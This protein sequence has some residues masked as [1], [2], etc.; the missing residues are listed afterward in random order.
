MK[1]YLDGAISHLQARASHLLGMVPRDRGRELN[2]LIMKCQEEL[3]DLQSHLELLVNH[4]VFVRRETQ[5]LRLRRYRRAVEDLEIRESVVVAALH[6]WSDIDTRA[7]QLAANI[8]QEINFPLPVP[9]VSCTSPRGAYYHT[10]T[11]WNLIVIPLAEGRF[12]LH[13]PDLYHELAHLLFDAR[14]DPQVAAWQRSFRAALSDVLR[15]VSDELNKENR[16][17]RPQSYQRYLE[18]WSGS[19]ESWLTEF[20][21]DVFATCTLGPAFAWSH[22]HLCVGFTEAPYQ[23]PRYMASTHPADAARMGVMLRVLERTGHGSAAATIRD[24]WTMVIQH[25]G[26]RATPEYDR[27]YPSHILDEIA[28]HATQGT[29]AISCAVF[30]GSAPE[31]SVGGTL[32]EAWRF[33]WQQPREY[34]KW[35]REIGN[36]RLT[37]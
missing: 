27:C 32:N 34:A 23:V 37:G 11:P 31:S 6:R 7:N 21:C 22:L 30:D 18:T 35:E 26:V 1:E 28:G 17:S 14:R 9:V 12:L 13:F 3:T 15:Y 25:L 10:Y 20:F 19:W 8:C 33:F 2:A 29:I 16:G 24:K 5:A 4:P 36:P